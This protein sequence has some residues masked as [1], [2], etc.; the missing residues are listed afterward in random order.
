MRSTHPFITT[1]YSSTTIAAMQEK[2]ASLASTPSPASDI[3]WG[4]RQLVFERS[5]L[6]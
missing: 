4:M 1:N 2:L 3:E 5:A 6:G